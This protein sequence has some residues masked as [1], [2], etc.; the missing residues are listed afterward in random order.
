MRAFYIVCLLVG[1]FGGAVLVVKNLPQ[2]QPAI[3]EY[4]PPAAKIDSLRVGFNRVLSIDASH[5][6][7]FVHDSGTY[8]LD[9]PKWCFQG[10]EPKYQ[11]A[12][13]VTV[14]EVGPGKSCRWY[15]GASDFSQC[16][17]CADPLFALPRP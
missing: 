17:I 8:L 10:Q 15:R 1:L 3:A 14:V 6:A 12:Q 5:K 7:F 11:Y 16:L 2:P 4:P 9:I 13:G